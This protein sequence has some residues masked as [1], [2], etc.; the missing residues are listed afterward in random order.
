MS[1]GLSAVYSFYDPAARGSSFGTYV[2]LW[3]ASE[4]SR[5]GLPY[6]YL[7]YWIPE[8]NKM[9]YKSRFAPLEFFGPGGWQ[10]LL[11]DEDGRRIEGKS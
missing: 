7:G 5:L 6:V 8:S 10:P 4:A 3:L 11:L 2:I 9:S 1:D